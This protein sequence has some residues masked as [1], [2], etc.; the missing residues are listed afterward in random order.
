MV[1]NQVVRVAQGSKL[2]TNSIGLQA[3]AKVGRMSCFSVGSMS[4]R[5]I[6]EATQ[7][8]IVIDWI[9]AYPC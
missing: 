1:T 6:V 5:F 2:P 4:L 8:G 9:D 3:L 7:T